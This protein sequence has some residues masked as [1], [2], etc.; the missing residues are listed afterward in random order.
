MNSELDDTFSSLDLE[1]IDSIESQ[2]NSTECKPYTAALPNESKHKKF[3]NLSSRS[4]L[5][6]NAAMSFTGC[7]VIGQVKK[8][9]KQTLQP[10]KIGQK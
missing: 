10:Q 4:N 8:I 5:L 6:L 9:G 2:H 3:S 1:L 7:Q